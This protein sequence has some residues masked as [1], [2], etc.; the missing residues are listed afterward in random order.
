MLC[1]YRTSASSSVRVERIEKIPTYEH[2]F[3]YLTRFYRRKTAIRK[4]AA[5]PRL[6]HKGSEGVDLTAESDED[7]ITINNHTTSDG[8]ALN[9][10][11]SVGENGGDSIDLAAGLPGM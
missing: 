8:D 6:G 9:G 3:D 2:A 4:G 11:G 7:V 1:T 10:N 5:R